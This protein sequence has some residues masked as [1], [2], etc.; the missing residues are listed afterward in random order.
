MN[1]VWWDLHWDAAPA[2]VEEEVEVFEPDLD[3]DGD[4]RC[5]DCYVPVL[6]LACLAGV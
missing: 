2:D 4:D 5:N 3:S 6:L 1:F